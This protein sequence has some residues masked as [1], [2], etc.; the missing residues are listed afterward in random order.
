MSKTTIIGLG[1]VGNS[2][3]LALRRADAEANQSSVTGFDPDRQREQAALRRY[4]SV[5]K[6]APDLE[7][8]VAGSDLIII[9]TPSSAMREVLTAVGSFAQ[10]GTTITDTLTFKEQVLSWAGE[11]LPAHVSFVGGHPFSTMLDLET[12]AESELPSADLFRGAPYPIMPLPSAGNEA[13]VQVIRLAETLGAKPLFMDSREHDS[14]V[15]AVSHLP[16][17]ASAALLQTITGSPA[18]TDM[19]ALA[20]SQFRSISEP[21]VAEPVAL[22]DALLNNRHLVVKWI[23]QYT[24]ALYDIR[25]LLEGNDQESLLQ[26]VSD[27]HTARKEWDTPDDGGGPTSGLHTD[28]RQ[29]AEEMRPG[30]SLMGNYLSERL[31]RKRD[32]R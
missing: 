12:A 17:I 30:R 11:L 20:H 29:V 18:W 4:F 19:S 32:G 15:A 24:R 28:L 1:L 5:D 16:S 25:D 3:G 31:F 6:I 7:R 9:A 10:P 8:A 23:D 13:L 27:A 14:F 22:R 26:I 21:L 2:I